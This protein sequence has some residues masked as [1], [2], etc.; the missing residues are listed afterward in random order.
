MYVV[1]VLA[2]LQ[3]MKIGGVMHCI[4][5]NSTAGLLKLVIVHLD[6]ESSPNKHKWNINPLVYRSVKGLNFIMG[7]IIS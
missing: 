6:N 7:I 5:E 3:V 1:V 4:H 2:H